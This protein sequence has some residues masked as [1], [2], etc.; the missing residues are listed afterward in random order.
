MKKTGLIAAFLS[1]SLCVVSQTHTRVYDEQ[2][3]TLR[4][5]REVLLLDD[6]QP[7]HISFD[8]MSHDVHFYTYSV[9]MQNGELLNSEYLRGFTTKDIT[10]FEHSMNTSREYTHYWFE[11]PN[12][13]MQLT[14]SGQ[15]RLTIY[16]D[17]NPDTPNNIFSQP[18]DS[19]WG[20]FNTSANAWTA[21]RGN[22]SFSEKC[23]TRSVSAIY[24]AIRSGETSPANKT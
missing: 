23:A 20:Q 6:M 3:R 2:I 7:L 1:F 24:S 22:P 15:Y 18:I 8:E 12:E 16:E 10:D 4:V 19:V 9:E 14:K 5:E 13:D 21:T 11:F 17:G